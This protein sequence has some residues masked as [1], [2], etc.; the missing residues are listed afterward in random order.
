MAHEVAVKQ[1]E[2]VV[3][4]NSAQGFELLQRQAKMFNSSTLVPPQYQ[5]EQNFGNAVI[6]LEMA[7]RMNASPLMVM[8][9]LYIVYGNP[10]WSS[11]F[12]ISMFNQ[13]G[14]FSAIKYKETGVRGTD[15]QGIVAYTTELATGEIILGPEVTISIAK[16][17][18]WYDKKGSK[19]KTMPDQML[20]YR[21]AAWLIR[22]TA[23][24]LSMG[25]QTADE[26]ID[27]E[28]K[29]HDDVMAHVSETIESN[30]NTEVLDIPQEKHTFVDVETGEV[31][32]DAALF[33]D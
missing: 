5:G 20:R 4:F 1:S 13:C 12:L 19:W 25:L 16:Q 14:R 3:G 33:G 29:V 26:V 24:E 21:A 10:G 22:T 7:S 27:V 9:N 23:P 15:S 32:D 18:G 2:V 31:I 17:E 28:G 8:Q 30:A 6:A 11:K